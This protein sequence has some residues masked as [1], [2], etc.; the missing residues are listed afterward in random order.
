MRSTMRPTTI[1]LVA[2]ALLLASATVAFAAE[3]A[4]KNSDSD[5]GGEKKT[6]GDVKD[7]D[8][9]EDVDA[10]KYISPKDLLGNLTAFSEAI[11][12]AEESGEGEFSVLRDAVKVGGAVQVERS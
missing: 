9:G 10:P 7:S 4:Q 1:A 2:L 8:Y 11:S 5:G 12:A 6:K 3:A